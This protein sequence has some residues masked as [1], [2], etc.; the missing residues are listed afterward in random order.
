ME[1]PLFRRLGIAVAAG[2]L[3]FALNE[4]PIAALAPF[5][6][7]RIV[8]LPVAILYGPWYGV[9]SALMALAGIAN[10]TLGVKV[11]M[12]GLEAIAIGVF[13][14]RRWSSL[15]GGAI[16]WVILAAALMLLQR[17]LADRLAG[18]EVLR[19]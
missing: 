9:L 3:G 13:A 19:V 2:A 18:I 10:G 17:R 15:A 11:I 6:M 7:G 12:Y 8:T 16:F 4:V 14:R 1:R 5:A